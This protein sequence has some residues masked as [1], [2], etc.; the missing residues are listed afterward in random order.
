MSRATRGPAGLVAM[1]GVAT[2]AWGCAPAAARAREGSLRTLSPPTQVEWTRVRQ[3]LAALRAT[4]PARPYVQQITVAM[5]EPLTGKVFQ[6]RGALAVDPHRALRMI[7]LGPGGGTAL[8]VWLT[9]DRFRFVVP[10]LSMRRTGGRD[11]ASWR[12]LPVGFFRWW[13][14]HPLD[15][16]VLDGWLRN[17]DAIYLL[18]RDDETVLLRDHAGHAGHHV[19]AMRRAQ[20]EVEEVEWYGRTLVPHEGDKARYVHVTSGLEVEVLVESVSD[21]EPD[22]A[23]FFDPDVATPETPL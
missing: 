9:D 3:R 17:G 14:L 2:L 12:G 15:G 11:A 7:L 10:A 18:R 16:R 23:A 4:Q 5:R 1:I 8:D 20:G 22:P 21:D 6:A 13:M 19:L